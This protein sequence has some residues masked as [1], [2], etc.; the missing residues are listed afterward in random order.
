MWRRQTKTTR[1]MCADEEKK[2]SLDSVHEGDVNTVS[3]GKDSK[4]PHHIVQIPR[5]TLTLTD[6]LMGFIDWQQNDVIKKY[7][8][9]FVLHSWGTIS[10]H[11]IRSQLPGPLGSFILHLVSTDL[12]GS[13]FNRQMKSGS[14][15]NR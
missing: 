11:K 15:R 3:D 12:R 14:Q 2:S 4:T 13:R 7:L 9:G 10:L 5:H 6:S 1:Y 8:D